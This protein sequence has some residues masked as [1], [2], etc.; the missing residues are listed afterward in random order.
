MNKKIALI[1]TGIILAILIGFIIKTQQLGT[2]HDV[3]EEISSLPK[4]CFL[5][6]LGNSFANANLEND[7]PIIVVHF[8]YFCTY[9]HKEA[10]IISHYFDEY[11]DYQ[12]LFVT[13]DKQDNINLFFEKNKL[14][15]KSNLRV[16]RYDNNEFEEAF[17]SKSL[18]CVF[19]F[20]RE[21]K[22]V[23][24]FD[25]AVTARTLIMYTRAGNI[26]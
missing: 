9:C 13:K 2:E 16:L 7:K 6:T 22:L 8:G 4:F 11:K 14:T 15:N 17:G 20:N 3:Q 21:L 24:H 10:K 1:S 18:P 23:K 26:R 25:G 5:D 12:L 19:I